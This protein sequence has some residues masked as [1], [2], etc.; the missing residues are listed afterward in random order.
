MYINGE[1]AQKTL[2]YT[3]NADHLSWMPSAA[4]IDNSLSRLMFPAVSN[5]AMAGAGT[6]VISDNAIR[7][8][9]ASSRALRTS[10]P[11]LIARSSG[12]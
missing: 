2:K 8:S 3:S 6:P 5:R 10:T 7:E 12:V 1:S 11:S 4:E 9:F